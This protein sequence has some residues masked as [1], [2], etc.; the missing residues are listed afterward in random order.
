MEQKTDI[1]SKKVQN[2]KKQKAKNSEFDADECLADC[3]E[4]CEVACKGCCCPCITIGYL[5]IIVLRPLKKF[6]EKIKR[7]AMNH[8]D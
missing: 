3:A 7:K 6:S 5:A 1:N 8:D 4:T 2:N